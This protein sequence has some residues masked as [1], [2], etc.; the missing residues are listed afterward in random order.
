MRG[1]ARR[2]YR[3]GISVRCYAL[4]LFVVPDPDDLEDYLIDPP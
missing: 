2:V 3:A 4:P 1:D